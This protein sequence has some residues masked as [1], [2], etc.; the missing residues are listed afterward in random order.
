[1]ERGSLGCLRQPYQVSL[2]QYGRIREDNESLEVGLA[3]N[4]P[5][6]VRR[7]SS[8]PALPHD[9]SAD[10]TLNA[11]NGVSGVTANQRDA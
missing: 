4:I 9:P 7:L 8:A 3:H 2:Y 10:E 11:E 6:R 5:S 1:M